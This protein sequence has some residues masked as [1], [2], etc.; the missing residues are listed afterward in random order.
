M[1][2]ASLSA[3]ATHLLRFPENFLPTF[4]FVSSTSFPKE[5]LFPCSLS[6]QIPGLSHPNSQRLPHL[7]LPFHSHKQTFKDSLDDGRVIL[8]DALYSPSCLCVKPSSVENILLLNDL[9]WFL[10]ACQARFGLW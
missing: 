1:D 2:S 4:L 7:S 9:Q 6:T 5:L 8:L 3:P 10:S